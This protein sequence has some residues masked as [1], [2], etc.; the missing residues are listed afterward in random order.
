M[1]I[2]QEKNSM[3]KSTSTVNKEVQQ[4]QQQQ[5][6]RVI[7]EY[8]YG[9]NTHYFGLQHLQKP[10]QGKE[11][12]GELEDELWNELE[13]LEQHEEQQKEKKRQWEQHCLDLFESYEELNEDNMEPQRQNT[14][15]ENMDDD[16]QCNIEPSTVQHVEKINSDVSLGQPAFIQ[17]FERFGVYEQ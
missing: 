5:H 7:M 12:F 14:P 1:H 11:L 17:A 13:K 2:H 10:L 4:T 6:T 16:D 3:N 8:Q 15:V 9:Q